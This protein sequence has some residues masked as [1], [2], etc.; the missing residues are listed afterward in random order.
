MVNRGPGHA[1]QGSVLRKVGPGTGLRRYDERGRG[2]HPP[3]NPLPSR[4]G[5][6]R[7]AV[8][9][10]RAS[11]RTGWFSREGRRDEV[12]GC[13]PPLNPLP[14]R[15]ALRGAVPLREPQG[16][17]TGP[18]TSPFE[19]LRTGPSISLRTNGRVVAWKSK[20]MRGDL[21][22][23]ASWRRPGFPGFRPPPE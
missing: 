18:S 15:E 5:V 8:G 21:S 2:C 13:H 19:S 14:S 12:P 6:L 7:W 22:P 1:R 3:L 23:L 17:R 10:S 20:R 11:G 16:E 9:P 4:E